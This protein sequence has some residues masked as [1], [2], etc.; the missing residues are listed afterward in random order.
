MRKDA[1]LNK[2][3]LEENFFTTTSVEKCYSII[4]FLVH[5]SGLIRGYI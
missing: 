4:L 2:L 1:K 3:N 5:E